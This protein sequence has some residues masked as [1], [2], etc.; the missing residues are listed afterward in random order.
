MLEQQLKRKYRI[1]LKSFRFNQS[2][3][4]RQSQYQA[5]IL[6]KPRQAI[7]PRCFS[8]GGRIK[9]RINLIAVTAKMAK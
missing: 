3:H 1:N 7:L 9:A 4:D 5:D 6:R 8:C 2:G